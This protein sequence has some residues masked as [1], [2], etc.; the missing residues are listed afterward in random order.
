[1]SDPKPYPNLESD[2]NPTITFNKVDLT[3]IT[4]DELA[5]INIALG[6][7]RNDI[8]KRKL[9]YMDHVSKSQLVATDRMINLF[10]DEAGFLIVPYFP[11]DETI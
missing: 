5:A 11:I 7:Y 4:D 8:V 10:K 3:F 6:R 9:S 2:P 1:M